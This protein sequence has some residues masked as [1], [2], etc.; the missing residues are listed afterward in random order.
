MK[1]GSHTISS[2]RETAVGSKQQQISGVVFDQ[3][4]KRSL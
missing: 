1:K 2:T 4:K 3:L